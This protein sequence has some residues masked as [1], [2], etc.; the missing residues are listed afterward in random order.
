MI[1]ESLE[2]MG[3]APIPAGQIRQFE[4]YLELLLKWNARL[5]LT[6]IRVPEQIVERHFAESTFAAQHLPPGIQNILDF[7]SGGGFP[8]VPIAICRPDLKVTLSESQ[9]KKAS[10]LREVARALAL[11]NTTVFAGRAETLEEHFD[12]I[13]LRAVDK[14]EQACQSALTKLSFKGWF[15]PFLSIDT[16]DRLAQSLD[17]VKWKD[18]IL[19]PGSEQRILLIGQKL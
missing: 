19:L 6:S 16:I 5:N 14:M 18:R 8:G 15:L 13:T 7:G 2:R 11:K 4:L 1:A 17:R 9:G 12:A 3:V 10:F